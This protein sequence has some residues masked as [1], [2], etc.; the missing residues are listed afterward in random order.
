M[1]E[2]SKIIERLENNV[3][4]LLQEREALRVENQ[5]LSNEISVFE[6]ALADKEALLS[7]WQEKYDSLKMANSMVGSNESKT[8]AK[9]KINTLIREIDHCIAQL[10][11]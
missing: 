2:L 11:D 10:S 5:R 6:G 7:N 9:L 8:A 1:S 4:Q 3:K